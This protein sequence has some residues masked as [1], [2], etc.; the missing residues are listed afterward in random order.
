M[1]AGLGLKTFVT[2][3]VLTAA[4]TNGYLMQ[5]VW[6]FASAAARTAAVTSPQAGNMSFLKDT[7]S[8][9]Y[10]NGSAWAAVGGS[11]TPAFVGCIL[12]RVTFPANV[13]NATQTAVS[14]DNELVDTNN[15]HST[16]TNP[17]RITIPTGYGGKYNICASSYWN[18][19]AGGGTR[20]SRI[21]KNGANFIDFGTNLS[22]N[23]EYP[24]IFWNAVISLAAGDYIEFYVSQSSGG[25]LGYYALASE[26]ANWTVEF[27]GA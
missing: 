21:Y 18:T 25:A 16:V 23:S 22:G 24:S 10:Y 13:A 19:S 5:G 17:T 15:F 3:D 14:F 12:N 4:D 27:L 7:N 1:A 9:E 2:G 20:G 26:G 8:T 6:V 11:G